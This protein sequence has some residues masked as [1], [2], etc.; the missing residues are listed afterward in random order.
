MNICVQTGGIIEHIGAEKC[1]RL[2]HRAGFTGIDWTGLE[3]T[4]PVKTIRKLD[5]RGNCILEQPLDAVLEHF[6]E[7]LALIR[8]YDLKIAQAHAPFPAYIPGHP[9][10]LTYMAGIYSRAIEVCQHVGCP[11]LV[12]HGISPDPKEPEMTP[13]DLRKMNLDLYEALIPT[14]HRCP[15]VTVCLEN[16]FYRR[17]ECGVLEGVC[18]DPHQAAEYIDILNEKAGQEAFGLCLDSGHLLLLHKDVRTYV[19]VL[20][21]RI[22]CLHLHDNDGVEDRHY[23]PFTGKFDWRGLCDSLRQTGYDADLSF[24][25]FAQAR[26]VLDFDQALLLP[27]LTVL[28][29]TGEYLRKHIQ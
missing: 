1:Y 3:H 24:E 4:L 10:V 8:K 25:T 17:P 16:L 15:D 20:G 9:E 12:I 19:P 22:K 18:S 5:H 28:C 2:I 6:S 23:A 7:E 26:R 14:L 13:A 11:N 21:K 27:W 29:K